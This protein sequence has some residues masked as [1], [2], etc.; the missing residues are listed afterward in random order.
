MG[1]RR[2]N[3]N[4]SWIKTITFDNGKEFAEHMKIAKLL[5]AKTY[6]TNPYTSQEKGTVENRIDVIRRIFPKKT[7][8]NLVTT[9]RIKE[10]EMLIHKRPISKF[11]YLRPLQTLKNRWVAFMG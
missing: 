2:T 4:S 11:N 6:F 3:F 8:L 7:D 1:E 9:Q 10:V 5:K